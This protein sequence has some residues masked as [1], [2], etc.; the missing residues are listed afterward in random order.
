MVNMRAG[1]PRLGTVSDEYRL[2]DPCSPGREPQA[3]RHIARLPSAVG[4]P[5]SHAT[6]CMNM[7]SV[8]VRYSACAIVSATPAGVCCSPDRPVLRAPVDDHLG[9]AGAQIKRECARPVR[10]PMITER[11]A[12]SC[13]ALVL[14]SVPGCAFRGVRVRAGEVARSAAV[15]VETLPGAQRRPRLH[16]HV[17]VP[18]DRRVQPGGHLAFR[19]ARDRVV[20]MRRG[21]TTKT[22]P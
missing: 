1:L 8:N 14:N 16:H 11:G 10:G 9:P 6:D 20:V 13:F 4:G 12:G 5:S 2:G 18:R 17:T 21:R 22:R 15:S 19:D 7:R 3:E